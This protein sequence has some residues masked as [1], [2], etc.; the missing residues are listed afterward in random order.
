MLNAVTVY[1][2]R[3]NRPFQDSSKFTWP[4]WNVE[5]TCQCYRFLTNAYLLFLFSKL[6]LSYLLHCLF[7]PFGFSNLFFYFSIYSLFLLFNFL[8]ACLSL[9]SFS[10]FLSFMDFFLFNFIWLFLISFIFYYSKKQ[11]LYNYRI[12]YANKIAC[13]NLNVKF[14]CKV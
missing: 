12:A 3:F 4:C 13:I 11:I 14:W 8:Y 6:F 7:F 5:T 2:W 9:S 10:L 1:A